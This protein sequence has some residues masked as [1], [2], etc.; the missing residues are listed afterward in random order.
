MR[1]KGEKRAWFEYVGMPARL[2]CISKTWIHERA[3]L[4]QMARDGNDSG[5]GLRGDGMNGLCTA[6]CSW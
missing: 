1:G 6:I 3:A 4:V 5:D 2:Y